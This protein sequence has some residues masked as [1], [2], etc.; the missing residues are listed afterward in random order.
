MRTRVE[1]SAIGVFQR[2]ISVEISITRRSTARRSEKLGQDGLR[3]PQEQFFD[4]PNMI[5]ETGSDSRCAA[6]E[7][8][9]IDV[10]T[11]QR[12]V[13]TD[14]MIKS[15][16]PRQAVIESRGAPRECPGSAMKCSN[17]L[18]KGQIC[19]FDESGGV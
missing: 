11:G 4:G 16:E 6:I 7:G 17:E 18:A 14:E 5:A 19:A 15:E 1:L 8:N 9:A 10:S 13:G 3:F 2:S 12:L